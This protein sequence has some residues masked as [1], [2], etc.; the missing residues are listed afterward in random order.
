MTSNAG[1]QY[2]SQASIGFGGGVSRGSAMQ[3]QVKKLFKPEFLNRLSS[4]VT[5]NDMDQTMAR[6]ILEK[7]IGELRH[8]VE[9][10]GIQLELSDEV[11]AQLLKEGF[12]KEYGARE[13]DRV[14]GSRLKPLLMREILYGKLRKGGKAKIIKNGDDIQIK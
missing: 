7:K 3:A 2:A 5:F 14:I 11:F 4:V 8:K 10:R 13:M 9:S 6:K 1:A 12:S